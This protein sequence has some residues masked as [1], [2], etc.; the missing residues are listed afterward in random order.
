MAGIQKNIT[1]KSQDFNFLRQEAFRILQE[2]GSDIWTDH[3][4]H[5]PGVTILEALVY[6]LTELSLKVGLPVQDITSSGREETL[7]EFLFPFLDPAIFFNSATK[8]E[9]YQKILADSIGLKKGWVLPNKLIEPGIYYSYMSQNLAF[10]PNTIN[11]DVNNGL[12]QGERLL[13]KGCNDILIKLKDEELRDNLV[14]AG[15]T[16]SGVDYI[17]EI[18][19]PYWDTTP[20]AWREPI[21]I[22]SI[23][24]P[25]DILFSESE[26]VYKAGLSVTYNGA[27]TYNFGII[28]RLALI[29]GDNYPNSIDVINELRTIV[30]GTI[31]ADQPLENV[32]LQF[33]LDCIRAHKIARSLE[34]NL[35]IHR[36]LGEDFINIRSVRTMEVALEAVILVNPTGIN[37]NQLLAELYYRIDNFFSKETARYSYNEMSERMGNGEIADFLDGPDLGGVFLESQDFGELE[38]NRSIYLSDLIANILNINSITTFKNAIRVVEKLK[39]NTY[40]NNYLIHSEVTNCLVLP[41]GGNYRPRLSVLKSNIKFYGDGIVLKTD[42]EIVNDIVRQ[43]KIVIYPPKSPIPK[44]YK[45]SDTN[46]GLE[47]LGSYHSIQNDFPVVFGI[48][49][50]DLSENTPA[51]RKAQARQ[52]KGYLIFFDQMLANDTTKITQLGKLFSMERNIHPSSM[53]NPL[54]GFPEINEYLGAFTSSGAT[55]DSFIQDESNSYIKSLLTGTDSEASFSQ[56]RNKVLNHLLARLGEDLSDFESLMYAI[57]LKPVSDPSVIELVKNNVSNRLIKFKSEFLKDYLN[58]NGKRGIGFAYKGRQLKIHVREQVANNYSW[59]LLDRNDVALFESVNPHISEE[60]AYLEAAHCNRLGTNP[61]FYQIAAVAPFTISITDE[62]GNF[63]G[64]NP[65]T[66]NSMFSSENAR[67]RLISYLRD[68]WNSDNVSGLQRRVARLLGFPSY[69]RR[70]LINPDYSDYFQIEEDSGLFAFKL[71]AESFD[72][73]LTSQFIYAT[74]ADVENAI[75][76]TIQSGI[77]E[78]NYQYQIVNNPTNGDSLL[79]ELNEIGT[80]NV[81]GTMQVSLA[82]DPDA[83]QIIDLLQEFF[84][85]A[86]GPQEGFYLLEHVLLRPMVTGNE[87]TSFLPLVLDDSAF[88]T[89]DPYSYRVSVLLPTEYHATGI[90][91]PPNSDLRSR[92]EHQEFCRFVEKTIKEEC[93]A[94]IIVNIHW[95]DSLTLIDFQNRYREWLNIGATYRASQT[96]LSSALIHLIDILNSIINRV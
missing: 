15:L 23:I 47:D 17:L 87:N 58:V 96:Q 1:E 33:N 90:L 38:N 42:L 30:A 66:F 2:I 79:V 8:A 65:A 75:Y 43:K 49:K 89:I 21:A 7:R 5:D 29:N 35:Q 28:G 20:L 86:L 88:S 77:D 53:V 68:V 16:I 40:I 54:Y 22:N 63:I 25:N 45:I 57:Y 80:N 6:A 60:D 69:K 48:K 83:R 93:P 52:L 41:Q 95:V 50:G 13:L 36:N 73:H 71:S 59:Q 76:T 84:T 34:S 3:N 32:I 72:I 74:T 85:D 18:A 82:K 10:D 70:N 19:L 11:I 94:H 9:D 61:I 92:F 12:P 24:L 4:T 91:E 27:N 37:V 14:S 55:W 81:L 78:S 31:M 51:I 64:E 56:K 39:L 67:G 26:Q 46:P 62:N 44:L